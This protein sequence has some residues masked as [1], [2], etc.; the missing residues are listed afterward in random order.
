MFLKEAKRVR[1]LVNDI[2]IADNWIKT[3]EEKEIINVDY[4]NGKAVAHLCI[5][6]PQVRKELTQA[7]IDVY[8]ERRSKAV[9]ELDRIGK[10]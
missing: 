9:D 6:D 4:Q 7:L 2:E 5:T 10:E 3:F 8:T 1:K